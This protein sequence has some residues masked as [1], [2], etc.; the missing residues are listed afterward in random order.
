[1]T[2]SGTLALDVNG[3]VKSYATLTAVRGLGFSVKPG[4]VLA[5]V[6]PNGAGKTTTMR[7]IAGIL[8]ATRGTIAVGGFD[9]EK[10]PV[11]AKRRVAYVPD[12]PKLFDNLTVWEHLEFIAAA[13]ELKQWQPIAD[14]WLERFEL[15]PKR[16]TPT[17]ELSR[18]MRQ[19][20]AVIAAYVRE[21][22]FIM[23]DEPMTGLDPRGIRTMKDSIRERSRA[24][25]G[26][27]LSSHLLALVE[28]LCDALLIMHKGQLVFFGT[29]MEARERF[30]VS[31]TG[32]SSL[33]D[34]F[35]RA[36]EGAAN[37]T[38]IASVDVLTPASDATNT[39]GGGNA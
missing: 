28:D 27:M 17:S 7:C 11:E 18:G 4:Q 39:T 5:M 22:A 9:L 29:V 14:S 16:D 15:T 26:V 12:D 1:M 25:A 20:I 36:T 21:P 23:L 6:G 2:S 3:L 34:V 35:F 31:Q 33:E 37:A 13:Y 19:K 32:D 8:P 30:G 10:Q 24:G 38:A